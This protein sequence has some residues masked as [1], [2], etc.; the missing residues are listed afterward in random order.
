MHDIMGYSCFLYIYCGETV[1]PGKDISLMLTLPDML[2]IPVQGN[3]Y[4]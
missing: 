4:H 2:V 1:S 3:R